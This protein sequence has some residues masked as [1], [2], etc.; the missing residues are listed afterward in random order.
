MKRKNEI[1]ISFLVIFACL[2]GFSVTYAIVVYLQFDGNWDKSG[3]FGDSFGALNSFLT[4]LVLIGTLGSLYLFKKQLDKD[5]MDRKFNVFMTGQERLVDRINFTEIRQHAATILHN[6][7]K[8]FENQGS[9]FSL[10]RD[11]DEYLG[12]HHMESLSYVQLVSST[13]ELLDSADNSSVYIDVLRS[14]F[15]KEQLEVIAIYGI[16]SNESLLKLI[17]KLH[18]L[19]NYR[20]TMIQVPGGGIEGVYDPIST[21]IAEHVNFRNRK[22]RN[23]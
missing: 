13:L 1:T 7:R 17:N 10:S 11:F 2:L 4:V 22:V 5:S 23:G 6:E 18:L 3:P 14:A 21:L 19:R 16:W 15:T 8:F 9:E 12:D 20:P